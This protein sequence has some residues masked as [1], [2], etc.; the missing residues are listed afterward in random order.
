MALSLSIAFNAEVDRV[1]D[2][3]GV[4]ECHRKTR[5][6][7]VFRTIQ[8]HCCEACLGDAVIAGILEDDVDD[9]ER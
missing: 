7:G 2:I 1:L 8:Q 4:V 3:S 9:A 5:S 6:S